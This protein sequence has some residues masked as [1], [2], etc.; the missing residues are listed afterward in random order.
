VASEIRV[1]VRTDGD[2]VLARQQGRALARELDFSATDTTLIATAISEVARNIIN[3]ATEGEI[4][5]AIVNEHGR[6][7]I[8]VVA[9]DTGPGIDDVE[10]ALQDGYS[11]GQGMGYGLP[12]ARRLVDDFHIRSVP[13]EG[14]TVTMTKWSAAIA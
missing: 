3:Y 13:G 6:R 7:G 12:G 2:V 4:M 8:R 9:L 10:K 5:I 1:P 11:T 14:T